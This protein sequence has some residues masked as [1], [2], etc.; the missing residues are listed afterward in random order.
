MQV[1]SVIVTLAQNDIVKN[2]LCLLSKK[3]SRVIE[4]FDDVKSQ[5][6]K[7]EIPSFA[8]GMA[9]R[10]GSGTVVDD[11]LRGPRVFGEVIVVTF[12]VTDGFGI[13]T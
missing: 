13:I 10:D 7:P 1:A 11:A 2:I 8:E 12:C 4:L 5:H 6:Q 3:A 9:H